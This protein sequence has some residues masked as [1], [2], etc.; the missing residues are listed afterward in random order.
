MLRHRK[1][2]NPILSFYKSKKRE[3]EEASK[4]ISS[5]ISRFRK[6]ILCIPAF[7]LFFSYFKP[8]FDLIV[9]V[10]SVLRVLLI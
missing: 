7:L 2:T 10:I 1:Q 6:C 4:N 5:M 9:A 3:Y 8:S